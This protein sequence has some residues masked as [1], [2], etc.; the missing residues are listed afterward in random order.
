MIECSRQKILIFLA[1]LAILLLYF[2]IPELGWFKKDEKKLENNVPEC[3]PLFD[4]ANK[5]ITEAMNSSATIL[6]SPEVYRNISARC[7]EAIECVENSPTSMKFYTLDGKYNPCIF[8][9]FYQG[10]FAT[11]ADKLIAKVGAQIPCIEAV[12]HDRFENK[13]EKCE[14]WNKSRPCIVRSILN[15][16]ETERLGN[17]K[18][19]GK[20]DFYS[21]MYNLTPALCIDL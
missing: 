1:I 19:Q 13:T 20:P 14:A 17:G 3:I 18:K 12:F 7:E 8:F 11:C 2:V 6:H 16:C 9:V 4:K 21:E 10:P 5:M 15:S